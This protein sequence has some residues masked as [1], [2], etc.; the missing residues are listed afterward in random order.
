MHRSILVVDDHPQV[1]KVLR[2]FLETIGTG[3]VCGEAADGVEAIEKANALQP[4]LVILDLAMPRMNG[5]EAARILRSKRQDMTIFL[6]TLYS[7]DVREH[8]AQAAGITAVFSK[9]N[10]PELLRQ[11]QAVLA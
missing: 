10:L 2:T 8:E 6:F 4:D 1:R 5:L 9:G 7:E 3:C 11:A